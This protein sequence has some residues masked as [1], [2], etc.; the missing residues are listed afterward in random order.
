LRPSDATISSFTLEEMLDKQLL[1]AARCMREGTPYSHLFPRCA[2]S[3]IFGRL[4]AA[5]IVPYVREFGACAVTVLSLSELLANPAAEV[6]KIGAWLGLPPQ[7]P[8]AAAA[9]EAHLRRLPNKTKAVSGIGY[10][11]RGTFLSDSMRA[12]LDEFFALDQQA[13]KKLTPT[14]GP[15]ARGCQAHGERVAHGNAQDAPRARP[16]DLRAAARYRPGPA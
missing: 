7:R 12:R 3:G 16:P 10:S 13:L 9:I 1:M 5:S 8:Q 6:A 4:F 14:L 2:T 15:T 11:A